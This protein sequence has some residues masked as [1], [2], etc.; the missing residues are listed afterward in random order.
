MARSSYGPNRAATWKVSQKSGPLPRIVRVGRPANDN[1]HRHRGLRGLLLLGL[2]TALLVLL[3]IG[4]RL[5]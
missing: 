1:Q 2:A 5:T 3:V 4:T